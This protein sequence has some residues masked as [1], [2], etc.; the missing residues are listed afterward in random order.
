MDS[1]IAGLIGAGIGAIAGM[2]GTLIAHSL[3]LKSEKNKWLLSKREEAYSNAL[4]YLLKSL[5][6]RSKITANGTAILAQSEMPDWFSNLSE[7][8]SWI[9]VLTIYSSDET[10]AS[11]S[12]ISS[13]LNGTISMLMGSG[14]LIASE[15]PETIQNDTVVIDNGLSNLAEMVAFAYTEI[16]K[17][18]QTDLGKHVTKI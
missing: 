3:Q 16:L 7:A 6:Q 15:Q 13:K 18:A 2:A 10:R 1:A 4:R 14:L 9:T 5:N 17:C 11:I 8:Q 12:N